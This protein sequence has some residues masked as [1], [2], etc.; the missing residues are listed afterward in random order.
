[1][2]NHRFTFNSKYASADGFT[3]ETVYGTLYAFSY[4]IEGFTDTVYELTVPYM[5]NFVFYA[6]GNE[7]LYNLLAMGYTLKQAAFYVPKTNGTGLE[8]SIPF[9]HKKSPQD[10][11]VFIY[12]AYDLVFVISRGY[13]NNQTLWAYNDSQVC[14]NI[15]VDCIFD[16]W[17]EW[18]SC[19][20]S[21]GAGNQKRNRTIIARAFERDCR[22]ETEETKICSVAQCPVTVDQVIVS[23]G[24]EVYTNTKL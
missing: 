22:N 5:S 14:S 19:S 2:L 6:C 18:S 23:L 11:S 7:S 16:E 12:F 4:Y 9:V 17:T 21:C 24:I 13:Y 20:A 10:D 3:T 1:M 15:A 8:I